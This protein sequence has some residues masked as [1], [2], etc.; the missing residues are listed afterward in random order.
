[1]LFN[2]LVV[3]GMSGGHELIVSRIGGLGYNRLMFKA[4]I[5]IPKG[6]PRRRHLKYDKSGFVDLGPIKDEIPINE[7]VMPVNY[8]LILNTVNQEEGSEQ[9]E[10]L[11]VLV[12]SD[13]VMTIGE[14]VVIEPIAFI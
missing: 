13:R 9:S 10:E 8:G 1:M 14:Q 5:E 2:Q 12:I 4:L 11:D 3:K 7:G 6:D